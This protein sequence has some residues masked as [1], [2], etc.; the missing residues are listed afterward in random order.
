MKREINLL[1]SELK[2]ERRAEK[3]KGSLAGLFL[4]ILIVTAAVSVVL[5]G[6]SLNFKIRQESLKKE[7]QSVKGK[8]ADLA[9]VELE[10]SRL[11]SKLQAINQILAEKNQYSVLLN[12]ISESAPAEVTITSLSTFGDERVAVSGNVQSYAT[13]SKLITSFLDPALGGKVFKS[14]DLTGASLDEVS[15]KI[16]FSLTLHIV[17][18][19]LRS[20]L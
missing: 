10:A 18:K 8:I 7:S 12:S 6:V 2:S 4:L 19:S 14:A 3:V 11:E 1:P 5:F 15:G 13:L 9:V 17:T 20:N 16:K